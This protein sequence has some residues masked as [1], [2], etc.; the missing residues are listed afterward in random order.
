MDGRYL[1]L[2]VAS[3]LIVPALQAKSQHASDATNQSVLAV[4]ACL[5]LVDTGA[6]LNCFDINA[7]KLKAAAGGQDLVVVDRKEVQRTRRAL[8]G[9]PIPSA[10]LLAAEAGEEKRPEFTEIDAKIAQCHETAEGLWRFTLDDGSVW[11]TTEK[12]IND[13]RS[14]NSIRIKRAA[15]GS[16]LGNIEGMRAVRMHRIG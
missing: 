13:P 4:T 16:F 3:L 14:G 7:A 1:V 5:D 6:R 15:L 12:S 2:F 8:F 11:E 9:F 10:G